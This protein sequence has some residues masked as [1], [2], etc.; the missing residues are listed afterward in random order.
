MKFISEILL[1]MIFGISFT[2]A[3]NT[4][5]EDPFPPGRLPAGSSTNAD[6]S[7]TDPNLNPTPQSQAGASFT[8][9]YTPDSQVPIC[10]KCESSP[11]TVLLSTNKRVLNTTSGSSAGSGKPSSSG[12]GQG[13]KK[14]K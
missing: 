11:S 9:S 8:G 7:S 12:S 10:Q 2:F 1:L 6:A 3:V 14:N 5:A 13:V 4:F